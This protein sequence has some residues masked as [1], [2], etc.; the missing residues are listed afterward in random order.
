MGKNK[1]SKKWPFL[2]GKIPEK[3]NSKT[4]QQIKTILS[5][6]KNYFLAHADD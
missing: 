2:G 3:V 4:F 1:M 6:Y 5:H